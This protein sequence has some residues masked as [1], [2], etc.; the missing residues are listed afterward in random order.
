MQEL[1]NY[2]AT[3]R[4]HI[5]LLEQYAVCH[6]VLELHLHTCRWT[7]TLYL[8]SPTCHCRESEKA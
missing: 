5:K 3:S 8:S 6:L 7:L 4:S 1:R 2:A